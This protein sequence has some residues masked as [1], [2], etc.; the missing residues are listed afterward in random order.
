MKTLCLNMIVKNESH[1]IKRC[2]SSIKSIIDYWVIVD[3]GSTDGTQ[4]MIQEML[5]GVPGEL[6]EKPWVNFEHNRN[7]ALQIA[8]KKADYLFF[9]D[10]DEQ[11][12]L[13]EPF[14]KL[15][16]KKDFYMIKAG[17]QGT[18]FFHPNIVS[19][20]SGWHWVGVLHEC[21]TH[22][23][24]M[25]G[26]ILSGLYVKRPQDGARS[27]DPKKHYKDLEILETAAKKEPWNSRHIFYIAQTYS[28]LKEYPLAI[29]YYEK[30]TTMEGDKD[31]LFWTFFRLACLQEIMG[32]DPHI[33]ITNH[34]KAHQQNSYRAEPLE[35]MAH[36]YNTQKCYSLAYMICKFGVAMRM[37]NSL[38][39]DF[40]PWVYEHGLLFQLAGSSFALGYFEEAIEHYQKLLAV[41]TLPPDLRMQSARQLNKAKQERKTKPDS[42]L[43]LLH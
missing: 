10:A 8:R 25:A 22:T 37:P 14:D 4:A 31:E 39:S 26:E 23:K 24:K 13:T 40:Y 20:D 41:P 21:I 42:S 18:E 2:L 1:V 17:G 43:Q 38:N 7:E 29:K 3:T 30:R 33:F 32:V 11:L 5:Q 9:F 12:V 16:L 35:R 36:Y 19:N 15:L 34:C 6:H 27:L 28:A